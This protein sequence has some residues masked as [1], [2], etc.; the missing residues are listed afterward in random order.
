MILVSPQNNR[1]IERFKLLLEDIKS[2]KLAPNNEG[3]I[4]T[5]QKK[6]AISG[7]SSLHEK[8]I[9]AQYKPKLNRNMGT[10][11]PLHIK[12][13]IRNNGEDITIESVNIREAGILLG[14][15]KFP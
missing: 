9:L 13:D 7:V 10:S 15:N 11:G 14:P 12:L 4:I 2:G 6:N 3:A 8:Q 1:F 5:S